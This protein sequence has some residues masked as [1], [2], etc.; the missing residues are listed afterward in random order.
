MPNIYRI[1]PAIGIA[2]VGD[3]ASECF[4]GPEA[5]GVPPSLNRPNAPRDPSAGYKDDQGR[6]K[7]QGA[8]FRI[9]EYILRRGRADT[10]NLTKLA[11]DQDLLGCRTPPTRAAEP[12]VL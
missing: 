3:S 7:R 1:H 4:V 8:R 2:R 5:P 9:Y 6:I 11:E 10:V 12:T